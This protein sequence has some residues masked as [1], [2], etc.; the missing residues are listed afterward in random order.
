M[1]L[2]MLGKFNNKKINI[3]LKIYLFNI[4]L[5]KKLFGRLLLS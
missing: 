4:L 2:G 1:S 5:A 3:F